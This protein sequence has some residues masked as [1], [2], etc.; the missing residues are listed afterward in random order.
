MLGCSVGSGSAD[1]QCFIQHLSAAAA[2]DPRQNPK[3]NPTTL[4]SKEFINTRRHPIDPHFIQPIQPPSNRRQPTPTDTPGRRRR[5]AEHLPDPDG[6]GVQRRGS[7]GARVRR[8]AGRA[9]K[10]AVRYGGDVRADGSHPDV[11][12]WR[13]GR[14]LQP[15]CISRLQPPTTNPSNAPFN[16]HPTDPN[17]QQTDRRAPRPHRRRQPR[18]HAVCD[19]QLLRGRAVLRGAPHRG[20]EV[21]GEKFFTVSTR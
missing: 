19:V 11:R 7:G 14:C 15:P 16:P 9:A 18:R 12:F 21:H 1:V 6:G 17:R 4:K 2:P 13:A 8:A 3:S 20:R 5:A 10:G